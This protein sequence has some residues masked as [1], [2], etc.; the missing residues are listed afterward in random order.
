MQFPRYGLRAGILTQLIFLIIAAM[1]LINLAMLKFWERD[2]INEKLERSRSLLNA[3]EYCSIQT[4]N[5][6][7]R[8]QISPKELPRIK[9][10]M[11]NFFPED[12]YR[13]VVI[14]DKKGNLFFHQGLAGELLARAVQN[15]RQ[16]MKT[17]LFEIGYYGRVWGVLWPNH[18]DM[19][20]SRPFSIANPFQGAATVASSLEPVYRTLRQSEKIV[21][22]YILLDAIVLAIAGIYLISRIAVNPLHRLLKMTE[23]YQMGDVLPSVSEASKNEIGQLSL[24]LSNMLKR[25]D[26]NKNEREAYISNLENINQELQK[27]QTEIIRSEK[28]ASVGR[29][30]AGIAHEIG[31]PLGI[32]LGY[33]E[34]IRKG[35]IDQE[36]RTDFLNRIET[37]I[38]RINLIIKQLL[39]FSRPA[40]G[41]P[42][43][44]NVHQM[45]AKTIDMLKPQPM[46]EGIEVELLLDAGENIVH[47]D[48]NQLQQVLVNILINAADVLAGEDQPENRDKRLVIKSRASGRDMELRFM[49]NGPGIP[50]EQLDHIFDPFYT[51]KE[52]GKGT[53]LGLS[54]CYRIIEGLNGKIYAESEPGK[55]TTIV[56]RV[57]LSSSLTGGRQV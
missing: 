20:I 9:G 44:V 27:A 42:E 32:I 25:L 30:S 38:L 16:T 5:R 40:T 26:D 22:L 31:N 28:L 2:L 23:A 39:D 50:V 13:G 35:Q 8:N 49:D 29:L 21:L 24:S 46:M 47:A 34:I 36:E 53:G 52:P 55:G 48:P 37:E 10:V 41:I 54:V 11:N 56:V 45:I 6:E 43:E 4:I 57:P 33:L 19:L 18:R 3:F 15:A 51:T 7:K 12:D 17:G 1:L 14:I